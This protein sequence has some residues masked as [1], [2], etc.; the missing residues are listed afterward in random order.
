MNP[1]AVAPHSDGGLDVTFR[2]RD[3]GVRKVCVFAV[4][5]HCVHSE[6][7]DTFVKPEPNRAVVDSLT[8]GLV[9]PVEIGLFFGVEV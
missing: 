4:L 5:V 1:R 7:V 6:T 9:I 2:I 8:C 3:G